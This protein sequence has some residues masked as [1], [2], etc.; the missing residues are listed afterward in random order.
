MLNKSC[1]YNEDR[2]PEHPNFCQ[3][4]PVSQTPTSDSDSG[5]HIQRICLCPGVF[6]FG[7]L[8]IQNIQSNQT[9]HFFYNPAS[10]IKV[11]IAVA[12]AIDLRTI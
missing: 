6:P 9:T 2:Y 7:H 11:A 5:G 3:N 12:V 10:T 4:D 8:L 1:S